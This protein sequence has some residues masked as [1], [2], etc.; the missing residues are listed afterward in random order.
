M[1]LF[2]DRYLCFSADELSYLRDPDDAYVPAPVHLFTPPIQNDHSDRCHRYGID[3]ASP[4]WQ[5]F[6]V[7]LEHEQIG[8][9]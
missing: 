8:I 3:R 5:Y 2:I 4:S 6:I 1:V 9:T 7:Q